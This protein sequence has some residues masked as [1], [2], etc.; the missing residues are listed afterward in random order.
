MILVWPSW[1]KLSIW[2]FL[3]LCFIVGCYFAIIWLEAYIE[4]KGQPREEMFLCDKH[5]AIS[6]RHLIKFMDFDYCP[7]CFHEKLS[8]AE[9]IN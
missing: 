8:E 4:V 9:K 2:I 3:G 1:L 6:K 5:G 7:M